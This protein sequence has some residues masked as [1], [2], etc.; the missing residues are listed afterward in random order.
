VVL[1]GLFGVKIVDWFP[2][3]GFLQRTDALAALGVAMIVPNA[4][5]T[6]HPVP[7]DPV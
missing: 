1:F 6:V 4:D 3:L 7:C 5:V 2:T